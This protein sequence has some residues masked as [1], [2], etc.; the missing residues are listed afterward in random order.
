[1]VEEW[2]EANGCKVER[3]AGKN[4]AATK[5]IFER[6]VNTGTRFQTFEG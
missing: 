1:M 2:L 4:A 6:L 3:I 5:R